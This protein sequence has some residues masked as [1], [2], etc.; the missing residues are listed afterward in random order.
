MI[1]GGKVAD[2][3]AGFCHSQSELLDA[4]S[5]GGRSGSGK[6]YTSRGCQ[7]KWFSSEEACKIL[8][9]FEQVVFVGDESLH[10]IFAGLQILLR[11][12][13]TTGALNEWNMTVDEVKACHCGDQFLR[14][15]CTAKW[16]QSS[17]DLPKISAAKSPANLVCNGEILSNS[18][19]SLQD[20]DLHRIELALPST[21][22]HSNCP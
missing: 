9:R 17:A 16:V 18:L 11:K 14:P 19:P 12:D 15:E 20:V 6:A 2:P 3:T 5:D 21:E 22:H 1:V 4:M 7:H 13:L 10:A 8:K